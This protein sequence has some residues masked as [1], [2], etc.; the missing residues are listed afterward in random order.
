MNAKLF[1]RNLSWSVTEQDLYDLFGQS[2]EVLSAKIPLRREDGKPRGFAFV[3][4]ASLSDGQQAIQQLNGYFLQ[5]RDLVVDIQDESRGSGN[6]GSAS[7]GSGNSKSNKLFVRSLSYSATEHDLESLFQ[8][9]GQV[10]SVKI[11]TDRDTGE[12]KGFGFV[13]MASIDAAEQAIQSL[14][15]ANL[16]GK[17]IVI[18][19]QDASRSKGKS[20]GFNRTSGGGDYHRGGGGGYGGQRER[21]DYS[22]RW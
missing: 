14:N 21:S 12:P 9:A 13:E 20:T 18:D 6:G 19:Y 16:G 17:S 8:Q 4:M 3:E 10:V 22:S 5:G 1:V 7:P 11:P 2:G 15:H